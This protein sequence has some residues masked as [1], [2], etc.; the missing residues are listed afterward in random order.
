MK[1]VFILLIVA[2]II[3]CPFVIYGIKFYHKPTA[4]EKTPV[5]K[6]VKKD[7]DLYGIVYKKEN[8]LVT[9]K[10]ADGSFFTINYNDNGN[11]KIGQNINIKYQGNI[12]YSLNVQ[13]IKIT[14]IDNLEITPEK[15]PLSWQDNKVFSDNY[16]KAYQ[17]LQQLSL[18]EKIGQLLLVRVP[19]TGQISALT[20]Y[21]LGGYI[22]FGRDTKNETKT[23]LI[24]KIEKYQANSK[25]PMLIAVDEEGGTVVRISNNPNLRSSKFSSPRT[26]YQNG[27]LEAIKNN[28]IEM[29]NLLSSLKVNLNLAPVVD[30]STNP[31]DF[32]YSRSLG[33]DA[34]ITSEYAKTII[35]SSKASSVSN[36]LKHFPGYGN[37]KDTHTGMAI[38]ER[39]LDELK[40]N[41]LL[42][43][44][45]G[46]ENGAEAIMVSH[47]IIKVVDE[48][49]PASLSLKVHQLA[50]N[51]LAFGG[52]L[53]TDD[54]DM[55]AIKKYTS[56]STIVN[57]LLADNDMFILSNY[58]DAFTQIKQAINDGV[59]SEDLIN[60]HTFKVL[61]WKYYKNM[62]EA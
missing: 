29:N 50:R 32:I 55:D 16:D 11:F 10:S 13:D 39:P 35:A 57:A 9:I 3:I 15:V 56:G 40:A 6:V 30:V 25:I 53:M 7:K 12:D 19:E 42:P 34:N 31:N 48:N 36:V 2:I 33:E 58:A 43:F 26:I 8:N 4:K 1:K 60:Y 51:D 27:G 45:A 52:I 49:N 54:L 23:S 28:N 62:I 14:K 59:I 61:A 38:D 24:N 17:K 20:N 47:N 22:L 18:D 21:F 46:A 5:K 41:D 37:N 44:K